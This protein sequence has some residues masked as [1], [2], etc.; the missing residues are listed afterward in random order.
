MRVKM[1]KTADGS[2]DGFTEQTYAEGVIYEVGPALACSFI[3]GGLA[4]EAEEA[5]APKGRRK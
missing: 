2:E 5:P 4:V 3:D 1:L